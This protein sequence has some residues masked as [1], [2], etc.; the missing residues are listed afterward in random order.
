[1]NPHEDVQS[2]DAIYYAALQIVIVASAT[3]VCFFLLSVYSI[4]EHQNVCS[5]QS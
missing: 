3:G 1:M 2:F 5:G 4:A